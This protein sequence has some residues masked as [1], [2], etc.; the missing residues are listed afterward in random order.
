MNEYLI[1][2]HADCAMYEETALAENKL[3]ALKAVV[4][5]L[6]ADGELEPNQPFQ[7]TVEEM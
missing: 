3:D 5:Q 6:I 2:I 1:T 7:Y 4:G